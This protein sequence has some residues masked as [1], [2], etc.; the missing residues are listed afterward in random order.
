[1]NSGLTGI[2]LKI[3]WADF[4]LIEFD[5]SANNSIFAAST[6][7]YGRRGCEVDLA[8]MLRDFPKSMGDQ[9]IFE[10]GTHDDNRVS[11]TFKCINRS[12]HCIALVVIDSTAGGRGCSPGRAEFFISFSG[13]SIDEFI[14]QIELMN[15]EEGSQAHLRQGIG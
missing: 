3:L 9:R 5:V 10:L 6:R 7:A 8:T 1:M 15:S 12:G 2:V 13:A 4:D 11:I 14:N